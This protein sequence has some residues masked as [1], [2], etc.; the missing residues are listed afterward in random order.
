M[1]ISIYVVFSLQNKKRFHS[2]L[3]D[4][5]VLEKSSTYAEK[6]HSK[7]QNVW[8]SWIFDRWSNKK[9][10]QKSYTVSVG[11]EAVKFWSL[12]RHERFITHIADFK[13]LEK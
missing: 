11:D 8:H 5:D 1:K 7:I 13:L 12:R 4:S 2:R 10:I 3:A 9:A 6:L